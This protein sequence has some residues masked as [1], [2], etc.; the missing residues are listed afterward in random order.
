MAK[1]VLSFDDKESIQGAFHEQLSEFNYQPKSFNSLVKKMND[2]VMILDRLD[3]FTSTKIAAETYEKRD[4]E[5]KYG[6]LR[7]KEI[8][9]TSEHVILDHQIKA[10]KRFLSEK[11]GF[12]LLAD[13][14]GSGKTF[15]AC[16]VISELAARGKIRSM[17]LVVPKQMVEDWVRTLEYQFGM[18]EGSLLRVYDNYNPASDGGFTRI[19][20]SDNRHGFNS[21]LGTS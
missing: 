18:G 7:D 3:D 21:V 10:A 19:G 17:L 16:L 4:P 13:V 1:N 5:S 8:H 14:V 12:G 20:I 6:I 11:R 2:E 9:R 15:E